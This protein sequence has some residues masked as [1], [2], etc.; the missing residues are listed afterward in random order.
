MEWWQGIA[1]LIILL[2][3]GL[4]LSGVIGWWHSSKEKTE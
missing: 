1:L 2:G 4:I 3:C